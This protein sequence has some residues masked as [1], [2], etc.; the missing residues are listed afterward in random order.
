MTAKELIELGKLE[1]YIAGVLSGNERDQV[2]AMIEVDP[3]LQQEVKAIEDALIA[4]LCEGKHAP[5]AAIR[6]R[7]LAAIKGKPTDTI[8]KNEQ[9]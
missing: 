3:L 2:N 8:S 9:A 4:A 6:N 1:L 5:G 7:V